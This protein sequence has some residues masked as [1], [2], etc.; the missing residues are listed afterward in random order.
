VEDI[1]ILAPWGA[2]LNCEKTKKGN[3]NNAINKNIKKRLFL[4]DFI[5]IFL[6][7][8]LDFILT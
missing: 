1:G 8:N 6:F 3:V 4:L 7:F 2:V 5:F